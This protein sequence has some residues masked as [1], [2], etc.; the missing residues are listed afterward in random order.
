MPDEF[1]STQKL[2]GTQPGG[3]KDQTG[4]G[5]KNPSGNSSESRPES[6][7]ENPSGK[8]A[9]NE[10][11]AAYTQAASNSQNGVQSKSVQTGD[12]TE[13]APLILASILSLG[14]LI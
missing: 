12:E 10:Q 3:D 9:S 1:V 4:R 11:D 5:N 6:G 14:I 8:L 2:G 7:T 13:A